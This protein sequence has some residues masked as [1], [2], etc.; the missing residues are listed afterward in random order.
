MGSEQSGVRRLS[1]ASPRPL[2]SPP[3]GR[4]QGGDIRTG[5]GSGLGE[6]WSLERGPA[7]PTGTRR[8]RPGRLVGVTHSYC[9]FRPGSAS[10]FSTLSPFTQRWPTISV[11]LPFKV[12]VR[13][14]LEPSVDMEVE[15]ALPE[16][17]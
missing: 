15:I 12:H 14:V 1:E 6:T 3:G 16:A 9:V 2:P 10:S 17:K 11:S 7:P 5:R 13:C 8:Q 4:R